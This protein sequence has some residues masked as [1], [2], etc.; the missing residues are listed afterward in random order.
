M[1]WPTDHQD[2][3]PRPW[4]RTAGNPGALVPEIPYQRKE[5]SG[6]P[7]DK[8]DIARKKDLGIISVKTRADMYHHEYSKRHEHQRHEYRIK[9]FQSF[10]S[11]SV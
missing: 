1:Y 6:R 7:Y 5:A 2:Q 9:Y 11:H 10:I 3:F 8:E 4:N